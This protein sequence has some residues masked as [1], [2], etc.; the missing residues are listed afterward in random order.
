[1]A[2]IKRKS[3]LMDEMHETARGLHGVGL[4][5]KR[6]MSEFEALTNSNGGQPATRV[7]N[8]VGNSK[9]RIPETL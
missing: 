3:R 4:L 1:M 6:R 7:G 2:K 8:S 5:S 9:N